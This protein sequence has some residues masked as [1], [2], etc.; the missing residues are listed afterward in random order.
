VKATSRRSP[1]RPKKSKAF[2]PA[3]KLEIGH[4]EEDS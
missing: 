1:K 2:A 4:R 3:R